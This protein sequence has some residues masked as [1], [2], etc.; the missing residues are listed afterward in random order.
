MQQWIADEMKGVGDYSRFLGADAL[1]RAMV[2]LWERYPNAVTHRRVGTS[3]LGDPI[4]AVEVGP[5]P[6]RALVFALPHPNEPVGGLTA[7]HLAHRIAAEPAL[8]HRLGMRFTVIACIDPDG[9][10]LNEGWLDGPFTRT[11]YARN[12]FRP[13]GNRQIEWTF[14]ID[15]QTLYFDA[16][17]PETNALI[18]E[19]DRE[20]PDLMVSLHNSELGG[21]YY[22]L[23]RP[24]PALY[25]DLQAIPGL[26][27]LP[28]DRGEPESPNISRWADGIFEGLGIR[29]AYDAAVAA[30]RDVSEFGGGDGSSAY[31]AQYGTL[32]LF[33]EVPY[34]SH[35]DSSDTTEIETSYADL[36][37]QQAAMMTELA[38]PLSRILTDASDD[39]V[40]TESPYWLASR[41]FVPVLSR[42]GRSGETRADEPV[43]DR[44]ATKAERFSLSDTVTSFRLRYGGMLL[45]ALDGELAIGNARRSI[46]E[47]REELAE[48]FEG[49]CLEADQVEELCTTHPIRNLVA[50]QY[51][52]ILA[53]A[54]ALAEPAG[55]DG[56]E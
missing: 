45:H 1:E 49:W 11:H 9:L 17:L 25:P 51:G 10:R 52:A 47:G 32:T 20:R 14:P 18:R 21:A 54:A 4:H 3:R 38:E 7:L 35:P 53:T 24:M 16:T 56:T 12:F 46:R 40:A 42:V 2:D 6:R 19:I 22:Y 50:T 23:S 34:W 41:Y 15:Y 5:G 37:R 13:A 36:L 44:L 33:S 48:R 8:A 31:A 28:L 43:N 30:G 26:V 39:V 55:R 27:D 29:K